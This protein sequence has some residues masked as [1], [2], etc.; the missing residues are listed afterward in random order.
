MIINYYVARI[1]LGGRVTLYL[2]IYFFNRIIQKN[3]N[4]YVNISIMTYYDN[5]RIKVKIT[6]I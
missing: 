1:F 2:F 5:L 3:K 6:I 4:I